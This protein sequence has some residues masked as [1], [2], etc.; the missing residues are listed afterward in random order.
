MTPGPPCLV[1]K[2]GGLLL[3]APTKASTKASQC[4]L[5]PWRID[6]DGYSWALLAGTT[7]TYTFLF[8]PWV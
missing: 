8:F 1:S 3:G 6:V 7:A 4:P 2:N 5:A